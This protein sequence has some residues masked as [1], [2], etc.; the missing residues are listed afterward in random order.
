MRRHI[1][2]IILLSLSLF[3]SGKSY[4]YTTEH[5]LV[6]M[7]RDVLNVVFSPLK[8]AF[9]QGPHDIKKV[10]NYEV[11]ERE[12]PEKRGLLRYKIFAVCSAPA[13]ELKAIIDGAVNSVT[14]AGKFF[15]ES[16]CIFFSD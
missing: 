15:K 10:Y 7:G 1:K 5:H 16:L 4:A 3:L 11:Y 2:I 12:K 9:I 6:N 8:G 13:V 14:S